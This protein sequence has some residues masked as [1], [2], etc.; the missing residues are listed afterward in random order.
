M[1]RLV[2]VLAEKTGLAVLSSPRIGVEYLAQRIR[3]LTK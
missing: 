3:E 1:S 2:D